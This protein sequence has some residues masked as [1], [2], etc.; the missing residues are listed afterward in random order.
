MSYAIPL[1]APPTVGIAGSGLRFPVRRI[2]TIGRNYA[3]HARETGL[4]GAGGSKPGVSLKPADS[5]I[6]DGSALPY[7]P[8]TEQLE[9]EVEMVA[10][11][12]RGGADIPPAAALDHVFG[13]AVGFDMI[14]RD[15]MHACIADQHSWDLCKS[16]DGASPV[17]DLALAENIGH[18]ARG[19]ITLAING[20]ERQRGDLSDLIWP[21]AEIVAR[22][23]ALSRLEP[24]DLIFTGTPKGPGK[25]ERGDRLE[26]VVEGIGRLTVDIA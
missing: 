23:S 4:G 18:P 7:P 17:S 16:F 8:G 2:Y 21:V 25:V 24:G 1:A 15:V 22:L 6:P 14:R 11:I 5:V 9:P 20:A 10:A 13:Y 26:G 3:A 19:A 12:G